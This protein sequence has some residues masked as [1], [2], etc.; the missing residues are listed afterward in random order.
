VDKKELYAKTQ[1]VI[2]Q[3]FQLTKQSVKVI[4]EKTGE[5]AHVTKLLIEKTTLEHKV[6]KKF[7]ELGSRVYER[8]VRGSQGNVL[9]DAEVVD[10]IEQTK[11]L[12]VSLAQVEAELEREKKAK[13]K[14][15]SAS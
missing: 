14:V 15:S 9:E 13:E 3:A 12:D 6:S 5:A 8:A 4:S 1:K 2:D 7:A 10:L 11:K